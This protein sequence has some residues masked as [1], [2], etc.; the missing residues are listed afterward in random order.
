MKEKDNDT[1]TTGKKNG[2]GNGYQGGQC[3]RSG[4]DLYEDIEW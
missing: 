2:G 1:G 3:R 4:K